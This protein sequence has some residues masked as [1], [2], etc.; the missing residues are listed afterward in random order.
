MDRLAAQTASVAG[1]RDIPVRTELARL[2]KLAGPVVAARLGIMA[3]GLTDAIVVGR[4]SAAQLGYHA[5]GW[6][7][8]GLV[9]T[10]ALGLLAGVQVMTSRAIGEG[11]PERAGAVLRRGLSYG[12]WIG[13]V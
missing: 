9:L 13:L 12:L 2:L 5:L 7:P 1:S 3:M 4:Y 6:T 11:R 10:A 8:N